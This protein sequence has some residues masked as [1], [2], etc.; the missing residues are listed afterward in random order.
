MTLRFQVSDLFRPP[1]QTRPESATAPMTIELA[2]ARV[3]GDV[4]VEAILRSLSDGIIA[5]G[6]ATTTATITCNRCTTSWSEPFE[7]RFEG[8][9]RLQ[10]D[11]EEDEFPVEAGGWIDLEPLVHDEVALGLPMTPF[12]RADCRGLCP[13]CGTDLNT[14]P[15]GGHDDVSDSPFAALRQLFDT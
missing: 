10:P 8:V 11:D 5:R 2:D 9:F 3:D 4:T 13:T 14:N 1:G 7:V 6:T 15:C 12:C